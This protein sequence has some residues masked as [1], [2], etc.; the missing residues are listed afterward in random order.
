MYAY[1]RMIFSSG[2]KIKLLSVSNG[3]KISKIALKQE[4]RNVAFFICPL[5]C[6]RD[7]HR[8]AKIIAKIKSNLQG[9]YIN[10]KTFK[11]P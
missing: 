4:I 1:K 11:V 10:A 3:V 9:K 5:S 6:L 8:Y 2:V 7:A